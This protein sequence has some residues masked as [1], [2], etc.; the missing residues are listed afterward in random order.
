M[1]RT[2]GNNVRETN[3]K[4]M[5]KYVLKGKWCVRKLRKT[6]LDDVEN[7]RK[8]MD[9]RGWVKIDEKRDVWKLTLKETKVL[10][11]PY[12]LWRRIL[13]A[14]STKACY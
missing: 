13:L 14:M 9:V 10:H 7:Y 11:G 2:Y 3:C 12:S 6:W 8:K 4:E 5:L 1:V